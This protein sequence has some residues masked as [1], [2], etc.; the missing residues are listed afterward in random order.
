MEERS[1]AMTAT[2]ISFDRRR[3]ARLQAEENN[4]NRVFAILLNRQML[5]SNL[6]KLLWR[7]DQRDLSSE[8]ES[9]ELRDLVIRAT[10]HGSLVLPHSTD[11]L[12]QQKIQLKAEIGPTSF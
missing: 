8:S 1:A 10:L 3:E 5:R 12:F 6:M 9:R 11:A 4:C 2:A 7:S